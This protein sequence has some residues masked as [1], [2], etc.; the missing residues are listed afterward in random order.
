MDQYSDNRENYKI[1][2]LPISAGDAIVFD[3]RL[4]HGSDKNI[5]AKDRFA[6]V[7]R[8]VVKDKVFLVC[9]NLSLQFLVY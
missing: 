2:S 6:Y 7:T 3:L 9:Q 5:D 8:W 1:K 4:W